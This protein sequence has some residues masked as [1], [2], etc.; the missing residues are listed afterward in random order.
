MNKIKR[1]VSLVLVLCMVMAFLPVG[2]RAAEDDYAYS[3][4]HVDAG[5]K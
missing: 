4:V 2:V 3:I 1:I 5:R